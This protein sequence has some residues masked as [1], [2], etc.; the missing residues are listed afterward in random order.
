MS[1]LLKRSMYL[2]ENDK[3]SEWSFVHTSQTDLECEQQRTVLTLFLMYRIIACSIKII[4]LRLPLKC[5][6]SKL[7]Q[8]VKT[9]ECEFDFDLW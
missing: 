7:Y 2:Q 4:F 6:I 1:G 5:K 8:N 3:T 9:A